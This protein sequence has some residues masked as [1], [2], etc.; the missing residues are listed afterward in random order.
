MMEYNPATIRNGPAHSPGHQTKTPRLSQPVSPIR[1]LA[2]AS[3]PHPSEGRQ[4]AN[5]NQKTNQNDRMDCSSVTRW[6]HE[7]CCVGQPK[8][9][10][11]WWRVLTKWGPLEKG[12]IQNFCILLPWEPHEQYEKMTLKDEPHPQICRCPVCCWRTQR[13]S[14]KRNGSS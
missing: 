13:Y 11:S 5:H 1:K 6:N 14:S 10:G 12:M 3:Y 4:D 9:D 2:Q 7:P 8:R